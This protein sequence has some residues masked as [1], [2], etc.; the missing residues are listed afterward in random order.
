MINLLALLEPPPGKGSLV[1]CLFHMLGCKVNKPAQWGPCSWRSTG[2]NLRAFRP[3]AQLIFSDSNFSC[4]VMSIVNTKERSNFTI[5]LPR[6]LHGRD[7]LL[8]TWHQA[9]S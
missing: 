3:Y 6:I 8:G 9:K 1:H 7:T 2:G 4:L 5:L